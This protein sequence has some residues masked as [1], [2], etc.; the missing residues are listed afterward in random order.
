MLCFVLA[1]A[2]SAHSSQ[3]RPPLQF[4]SD[5]RMIRLDVS[6]V[7]RKGAP[8]SGLGAERFRVTEDGRPV[9]IQLFEAFADE[10]GADDVGMT[11]EAFDPSTTP[12]R[13]RTLILVE[14]RV[15][16]LQARRAQQGA[17][18]F[19]REGTGPGDW[20]R[21]VDIGAGAT[22]EGFVPQDR[23]RLEAAVRS[24]RPQLS[25]FACPGCALEPIE[26]SVERAGADFQEV[27]T[28]GR[29]LSRFAASID[30]LGAMEAL[31]VQLG[32]VSGRKALVLVSPGF[33]QSRDLEERLRRTSSLA[34][35][36]STAIY[37]VD[38]AGLDGLTPG[39]GAG[40]PGRLRPAFETAWARSGGAQD[41]AEATGGFTYRFSNALFPALRRV[42]DELRTYYVVGY[43]PTRPDDGRFRRVRVEVDV[44]GASARTKIGYVA[45][46]GRP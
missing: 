18:R 41:L 39:V 12:P 30:L 29:F 40:D 24:L 33:P 46:N 37:F 35:E 20:V 26:D 25:P 3:E 5:V 31:L 10:A 32:G 22:W 27:E 7:D 16:P 14:T 45:G 43:V 23:L 34:R 19:L 2:L 6:V 42:A 9:A 1:A 38:V 13:R 36:S 17:L 21:I 15:T 28:T 11:V 8:V 4:R 44:P